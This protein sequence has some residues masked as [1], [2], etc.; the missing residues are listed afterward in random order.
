VTD[1]DL[2]AGK[3]EDIEFDP[4]NLI[5]RQYTS[6]SLLKQPFMTR[7]LIEELHLSG[8]TFHR[9]A[10]PLAIYIGGMCLLFALYRMRF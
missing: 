4:P 7:F 1:G 9:E 6:I 10:P 8:A 3:I 5:K 2:M